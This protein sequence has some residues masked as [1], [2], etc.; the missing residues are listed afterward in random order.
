V[1]RR[2]EREEE[3]EYNNIFGSDDHVGIEE[4]IEN[5]K[6]SQDS[7]ENLTESCMDFW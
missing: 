3:K 4:L 5:F 1:G 6:L 7:H 2:G